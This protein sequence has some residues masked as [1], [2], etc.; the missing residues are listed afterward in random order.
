MRSRQLSS[1]STLRTALLAAAGTATL[2]AVG[3]IVPGIAD[4]VQRYF[5]SHPLEYISTAMFFTGMAILAQKY[6][7]QRAERSTLL[8]AV[9]MADNDWDSLPTS[10]DREDAL[11]SWCEQQDTRAH[12]TQAFRRIQDTLHYLK[13]S[14]REGLEEHLRYLAELASDRLH[15]TFATIRTITWAIPILGFLGTV[16]GITMAIANVTPEQLDSS[17][18]EVTGGLAVAF[19]T[20]ALALGMSIVL[21]FASFV[22]E[23]SEQRILS[24]VE[25][26]GIETLL[27]WFSAEKNSPAGI[28]GADDLAGQLNLFQ[29]DVWAEQLA[30]LRTTWSDILEQHAED[31]GEAIDSEMQQTLKLHRDTSTDA[32]DAYTAALQQSA[33]TVVAQVDRLLTTFEHRMNSWQDAL[34]TSTQA[35]VQQSE[36]LHQLG[37]TLLKMTESEERLAALQQQLN[38]NLQAL[39]A[40]DTMEQTA[41][42]LAAAVHVLTAKTSMRSAA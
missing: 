2:Y 35:A 20:T 10:E 18:G 6:R 30:T 36:S 33:D 38:D 5:C 16:I 34:C 7:S 12:G 39:Q 13:G 15:Q 17:L 11:A 23:R 9:Q 42:S 4:F 40:A 1:T 19:D 24:D 32:R 21:V 37:A 41:N 28:S 26:F 27:P 29:P 8:E 25:Q 31:L 3:P 14:R 22:V